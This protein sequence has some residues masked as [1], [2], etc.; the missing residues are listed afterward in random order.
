MSKYPTENILINWSDL[1]IRIDATYGR[2]G[3]PDG[4]PLLHVI[5]I[6]TITPPG[7]P[8]P[9]TESGFKRLYISVDVLSRDDNLADFIIAGLD[10]AATD[11]K[12]IEL[13]KSKKQLEL[14]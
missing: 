6:K 7:H 10:A 4:P 12:W 3:P 2:Y 1:S 11:P 8:L 5:E 13:M 14:F 9:M